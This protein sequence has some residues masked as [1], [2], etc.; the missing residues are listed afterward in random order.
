MPAPHCFEDITQER[1]CQQRVVQRDLSGARI[2]WLQARMPQRKRAKIQGSFVGKRERENTPKKK[3]NA[4]SVFY[5]SGVVL[6]FRVQGLGHGLWFSI[7]AQERFK[8]AN[9]Q[10]ID[11]S[12]YK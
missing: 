6:W 1:G 11:Q 7:N 10:T 5:G 2:R 8:S 12:R 3:K 4:E 9:R